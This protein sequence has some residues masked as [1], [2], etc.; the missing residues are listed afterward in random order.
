MLCTIMTRR[1][2]RILTIT[3]CSLLFIGGCEEFFR[4]VI[5][6]FAGSYPFAETWELDYKESEVI[7]AIIALKIEDKSLQP[8][9][10]TDL[11]FGIEAISKQDS[12]NII[13]YKE[14][15]K[16]DSGSAESHEHDDVAYTN[17]S[18]WYYVDF[19]YS[20]TKEIVHTWLRPTDDSVTTTIALISFSELSQPTKFRYINKDF[21]YF[22]NR[23]LV[24]KFK[25]NIIDRIKKKIWTR[26]EGGT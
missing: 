22:S 25:K 3:F 9:N 5:G 15:L 6:G 26:R 12:L 7:E 17:T 8:P 11:T 24:S 20:D 23:N 18:Y 1:T 14:Y 2:K 16:T 10:Q 13:A 21:W 19:Y 4:R